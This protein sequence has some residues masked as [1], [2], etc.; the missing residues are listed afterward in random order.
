MPVMHLEGS[1]TRDF[2]KKS[3]N[4]WTFLRWAS[5]RDCVP[6]RAVKRSQEGCIEPKAV[7]FSYNNEPLTKGVNTG[8]KIVHMDDAYILVINL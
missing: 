8:K 2:S 4:W 5:S 6:T 3:F 7:T 1:S